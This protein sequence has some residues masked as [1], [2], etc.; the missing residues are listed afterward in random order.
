[1]GKSEVAALE[2]ILY[3]DGLTKKPTRKLAGGSI[4]SASFK[5]LRENVQTAP[6]LTSEL[7]QTFQR[8][9]TAVTRMGDRQEQKTAM[10][11]HMSELLRALNLDVEFTPPTYADIDR[12]QFKQLLTAMQTAVSL[13]ESQQRQRQVPPRPGRDDDDDDGDLTDLL[14]RLEDA[15]ADSPQ[16]GSDRSI[17]FDEALSEFAA[18]SSSRAGAA[19]TTIDLDA[20]VAAAHAADVQAASPLLRPGA[21]DTTIDSPPAPP[22]RPASPSVAASPA[23]ESEPTS[24]PRSAAADARQVLLEG[25]PPPA[26]NMYQLVGD[27]V[28]RL[29]HKAFT[30]RNSG[31]GV[32]EVDLKDILARVSTRFYPLEELQALQGHLESLVEEIDARNVDAT[33]HSYAI[34]E[35]TRDA[36]YISGPTQTTMTDP[37]L[38]DSIVGLTQTIKDTENM[39][40]LTRVSLNTTGLSQPQ[41]EAKRLQKEKELQ[42]DPLVQRMLAAGVLSLKDI[43]KGDSIPLLEDP[44]TRN[45]VLERLNTIEQDAREKQQPLAKQYAAEQTMA[46][47]RT[48]P[49]TQF[50]MY[51]P[52]RYA[53]AGMP[54]AKR[55]HPVSVTAMIGFPTGAYYT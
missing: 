12:G 3:G 40:R 36:S 43:V 25:T 41:A 37:A 19:D 17:D 4:R 52:P 24:S 15:T 35:D 29:A 22:P 7:V 30:L 16:P 27:N 23:P 21:T 11:A 10:R 53:K 18:S 42:R 46:F 45:A 54:G 44:T 13:Q 2:R 31:S 47:S 50:Q 6:G 39:R 26:T 55:Q 8:H 32:Y 5:S 48:I 14:G 51:V 1:M 34:T 9:V 38:R 49:N 20:A 33:G 28:K